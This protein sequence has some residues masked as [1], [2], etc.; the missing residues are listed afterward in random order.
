MAGT[1]D[2]RSTNQESGD[3]REEIQRACQNLL[4]LLNP[5]TFPTIEILA[6][7]G[8]ETRL[9]TEKANHSSTKLELSDEKKAHQDSRDE[10][11]S[12]LRIVREQLRA[13][14]TEHEATKN[15]K[16]EL[17]RK[18]QQESEARRKAE[19][20]RAEL[21]EKLKQKEEELRRAGAARVELDEKLK[22]KEEELRKTEAARA[23]IHTELQ[24]TNDRYTEAAE[25][26]VRLDS[27]LEK[28][29]AVR[30]QAD[31]ELESKNTSHHFAKNDN[32]KPVTDAINLLLL[33]IGDGRFNDGY[34]QEA[35]NGRTELDEKYYL[36]PDG[37]VKKK[38]ADKKLEVQGSQSQSKSR[39]Q[40]KGK[41]G[42]LFRGN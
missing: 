20:A 25:E 15:A 24:E 18:L 14:Q 5:K 26:R 16:A 19:V 28:A 27:E 23:K 41:L 1:D 33:P 31:D 12:R 22:Q 11:E 13:E 7:L 30:S 10:L 21:D 3:T 29:K 8:A 2:I 37:T 34:P 39:E 17:N 36:A 9:L 6:N 35:E 4:Q 32:L 38:H 42:G 40:S